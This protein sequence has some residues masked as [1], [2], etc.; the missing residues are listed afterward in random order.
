MLYRL[1]QFLI[2]T[3]LLVA[4]LAQASV[5]F[6]NGDW[7]EESIEEY[8][9]KVV[10]GWVRVQRD[11]V[12]D[13]WQINARWNP[14]S[15]EKDLLDDSVKRITRNEAVFEKQ[16]DAYAFG[17]RALIRAQPV[18]RLPPGSAQ[19]SAPSDLSAPASSTAGGGI[20]LDT[21]PGYRWSNRDGQWVDYDG[22]GKIVAY[23]DKNDLRVWL[24][25]GTA[26][27]AN[28]GRIVA[29][30]DH[31]GRTVL[32]YTY[33]A[34]GQINQVLEA[35]PASGSS[36][37]TP[38]FTPRRLQLTWNAGLLTQI[39]DVLG[40][41]TLHTYDSNTPPKLKTVT[42]PEGRIL[43]IDYGPTGRVAKV[44]AP[45]GGV[46]SYQ[47][48]Y[49]KLKRVFYLRQDG[50]SVL[51]GTPV[52]ELWFDADGREIR[53]DINAVTQS[54][55][56][57]D[58]A[59]RSQTTTD[60][61]G[62]VTVVTLDE[63]D[64]PVR[65]QYPDGSDTRAKYSV[66]HGGLLETTDE[67][68]IKTTYDY[69]A[70]GNPTRVTEAVGTPEQRITE[71]TYDGHGQALTVTRKGGNVTLPNGSSVTIPD[72]T[73]QTQ[74]DTRGNPVQLTNETG[75]VL[76]SSYDPGGRPSTLT[77]PNG[78]VWTPTWDGKGQLKTL[79]DP[80]GH[81]LTHTY[82]RAD[83]RIQTQDGAGRNTTYGYDTANRLTRIA[84]ALN[85]AQTVAYDKQGHLTSR[86]DETSTP[87]QTLAYDLNGRL[88]SDTD[89][90]GNLTAYRYPDSA[91]ASTLPSRIDTP[92]FS[93][94]LTWDARERV[95]RTQDQLDATTAY[96]SLQ[97]Y[98]KRGSPSQITDRNGKI[99]TLA[100]DSLGRLIT[101]TDPMS[102]IT[103]YSY[104]P[105]DRLLAVTDP[106]G[107][108]TTYGYDPAGRRT[109]ETR[110]M[111]ATQTWSY[112]PAGNLTQTQD[113]KGNLIAYGYDDARRRTSETYTP[114]GSQSPTR[115]IAYSYNQANALTG[116]TDSQ[117]TAQGALTL[118][119]AYTLD[120][121][122][123]KTQETVTVTD[124]TGSRGY[125]TQT[126]YTPTGQLARF[127]WPDGYL[128]QYSYDANQNATGITL[129]EGSLS[130][131]TQR[132]NQPT[133]IQLPGGSAID[134]NYDVLMRPIQTQ[135]KTGGGATLLTRTLGYDPESNI[136]QKDTEFGSHG[137]QYDSL[138][139]LTN[140]TNPTLSNEAYSYD[141]VGNRLTDKLTDGVF[142]T[143]TWTYDQ[144]NKLTQGYSRNAAPITYTWDENGSLTRKTSNDLGD[145]TNN[146]QFGYDAANRLTEVRDANGNPIARYAYDPYGRRIRK[147]LLQQSG[148]VLATPK[149]ID[150]LYSDQ[151]LIAEADESG[152]IVKRYGWR[153]DRTWG[154]D[155]VLMAGRRTGADPASALETFYFLNDHLGTPQKVI[156][157]GGNPVWEGRAL[158]FGETQVQAG[159]L[160][161][162]NIR[163]P[164][165]YYDQE[166]NSHYNW[167][168]T[169]DQLGGRYLSG[170]PIGLMGG[171][172]RFSYVGGNP[173][174]Y[175]DSFG[176][177][178]EDAHN[179]FIDS[180]FGNLNPA[181]RDIIK[182]GSQ[183]ADKPGFQGPDYAYMHAMSSDTLSPDEARKKMCKFIK[184]YFS[185]AEDAKKNN[186]GN[187][188]FYLG[189][190]L[191]AVMDSTSPVHE[192]FQKWHGV[193]EDGS[194][195]GPWP[196]SL[197]NLSVAK[198]PKHS[199]R[200]IRRMKDAMS[201]NYRECG[202]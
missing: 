63:F 124:S 105:W 109:R 100:Y 117:S 111:G 91:P 34:S 199:A 86:S 96:T 98:D 126:G 179:Y 14:L 114:A 19:G 97:A 64:N 146:Q 188:W 83:N 24:D 115:T 3:L 80:L 178:S 163:L 169:Y 180:T 133:R 160:V 118:T 110:P 36:T 52:L 10:G 94:T 62:L 113:A 129:P 104:D 201:G 37:P 141:A 13:K 39:T 43:A 58:S 175:T 51:A 168:R 85:Q 130:T 46:T 30:R 69:D 171:V 66:I 112:D 153:P 74:W 15:F 38:T 68:G 142:S 102:G 28:A 122:H 4:G 190:A 121:L 186:N 26:G 6:P 35:D 77:D 194:K 89:G 103:R 59:N 61:R 48:D 101:V 189:M 202:C 60:A 42:D 99:T 183:Y 79:A 23:G 174:R 157:L 8:R 148:Q 156:D 167:F 164:G 140:A 161:E 55:L 137:Y 90:N 41:T 155:P 158:A 139:R 54:K 135:A 134:L 1:L 33:D 191:H 84:N 72:A 53:R 27:S 173:V 116:F 181:I 50:P 47:Y 75:A 106:K 193:Y 82:D 165:Q 25:Y 93:R 20:V 78:K 49:D 73:L 162:N 11:Y 119:H 150:Y 108:T 132:W 76:Q 87:L 147:T 145:G 17:K 197:E 5:S 187:Y 166:T 138:Y 128:A 92:T 67:L 125:V 152:A 144:D 18:L 127:T 159:N 177:W 56:L 200:T 172:N 81:T 12:F 29:V 65:T 40:H 184:D 88:T 151:G 7:R 131:P 21:L 71:T 143:N 44:T 70:K 149:V 16:G 32:T 195:H 45:D 22:E 107:N 31:F 185:E 57:Q 182:A 198:Q 123:R 176:L 170:D 9:V 196:S 2:L 192:G 120:E 154:T 95:T 136:L